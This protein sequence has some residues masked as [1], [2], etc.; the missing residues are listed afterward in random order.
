MS[1]WPANFKRDEKNFDHS[2]ILC[3]KNNDLLVQKIPGL[4]RTL[5]VDLLDLLQELI[6]KLEEHNCLSQQ[7]F[8]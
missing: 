5:G 7:K 4:R 6:R 1:V 3:L 2:N 8:C